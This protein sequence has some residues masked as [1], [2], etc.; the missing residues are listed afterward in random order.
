MKEKTVV[1]HLTWSCGICNDV[2]ESYSNRRHD[3][4]MCKCGK[5]G[6]DL[7][8][9]HQRNMGEVKELKRIIIK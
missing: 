1:I 9:W 5:S 4:N 8:L 2:V 7:E 6:V 3:M